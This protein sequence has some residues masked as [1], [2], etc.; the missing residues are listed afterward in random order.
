M[1]FNETSTLHE[2][3]NQKILIMNRE[4]DFL[5]KLDKVHQTYD[6]SVIDV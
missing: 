1:F 6:A 5:E 4:I 2:K 3:R